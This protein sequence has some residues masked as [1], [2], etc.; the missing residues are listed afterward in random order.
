MFD[1]LNDMALACWTIASDKGFHDEP[2]PMAVSLQNINGEVS[3]LWE[4]YRKSALHKPCDKPCALSCLEEELADILI[5]VLDT[6]YEYEVDIAKA[7][8][9]KTEYNKKRPHRHGGKIA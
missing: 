4:A 9:L 1:K 8:K 2:V 6:A 3:E 7:V 5:R